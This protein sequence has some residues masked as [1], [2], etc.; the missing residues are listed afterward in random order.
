M[1]RKTRRGLIAAAIAAVAVAGGA[2]WINKPVGASEGTVAAGNASSWQTNGTVYTLAYAN[3][4]VYAGGDFTSVRPSGDAAG[5]GE[6]KRAHIAAFDAKT[7]AV[8]SFNHTFD[9]RPSVIA[10]APDGSRIYV[11]GAFTTVDGQSH[12]H[13]V[14]F[15]TA[16]GKL[17]TDWNV[18]VDYTV[19]AIATK[20]ERVYLAGGFGH[21]DGQP[22][23]RLAAVASGSGRVL[24]WAPSANDVSYTLSV[25]AGG[26]VVYAGGAFTELNGDSTYNKV[27]ALSASSGAGMP[28]AAASAVPHDSV[29]C[30]SEVKDSVVSGSSVYFSSEGTGNGCFDGTFAANT[31]DGSLKW[32]N[33]CLGATQAIE[34]LGD[35]LYKGSH[36]HDCQKENTNGD[37]DNYPEQGDHSRHLLAEQLTNGYLGPWYANTD[38]LPLGPRAMTTDGSSLWVGGDFENVN[39]KP[40]QGLAKFSVD[41]SLI[42][43]GRPVAPVPTSSKPGTVTVSVQAPVDLDDPDLVLRLYRDNGTTPI[44]Q[45]NVHS[46][47]W[48]QPTVT[49]TDS[50]LTGGSKHTY[51]ADAVER[52][53]SNI[54]PKSPVSASV[55]VASSGSRY[56]DS[57]VSDAPSFYWRL[58][59]SAGP[60]VTDTS[61]NQ[62]TG[63]YSST[64]V[65]YGQASALTGDTDTS[66]RTDGATGNAVTQQLSTPP[67]AFSMEAWFKTTTKAG[68]KL[69]GFGNQKTAASTS[70]DKMIYMTNTGQ[71]IFGVKTTSN[72]TLETPHHYNDGRWHQVVATKGASGMALYIDGKVVAQ[73]TASA[74]PKSYAGYWRVG[75]D[76]IGTWPQ[77]PTRN[78]YGGLIDDVAVYGKALSSARVAAHYAAAR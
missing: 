46:L 10:A 2:V 36:A 64:G 24:D 34:V 13:L 63:T 78:Y 55:T 28:F 50:G 20:G 71:L 47:F 40:Q 74:A 12:P 32:K 8:T 53:G 62:T 60:L 17:V 72:Q 15:D 33:A 75:G 69:I 14:A 56:E 45:T 39:S 16:T 35:W 73:N 27:G 18:T 76:S 25:S 37:P 67:S 44:A 51:T 4:A 59:E 21:V 29:A 42:K 54:S 70:F 9:E 38:G 23:T 61:G 52:Y 77:A 11:G 65:G 57:V 48:K 58:D 22:R 31:S 43:P 6:E 5:T 49:F 41:P 7:G 3:G 26:T 1:Q 19:S 68:G 30:T 66:I